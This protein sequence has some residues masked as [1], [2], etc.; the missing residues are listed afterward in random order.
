MGDVD[1]YIAVAGDV[2]K[3]YHKRTKYPTKGENHVDAVG[4]LIADLLHYAETKFGPGFA[5][6][7]KD[8]A[9]DHFVVESSLS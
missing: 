4:D 6:M 8:R 1:K 9:W 2:M 3:F 5:E 7:L